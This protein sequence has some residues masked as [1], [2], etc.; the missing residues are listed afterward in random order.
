MSAN[1]TT[2]SAATN[3]GSPMTSRDRFVHTFLQ[4]RLAVW[5]AIYLA[6]RLAVWSAIYLAALILVALFGQ[7]FLI[8]DP[9]EADLAHV[10]ESRSS[11][12]SERSMT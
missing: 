1:A 4:H 8:H 10:L 12:P 7:Q 5:S 3:N 6:D 2:V 9:N 11:V